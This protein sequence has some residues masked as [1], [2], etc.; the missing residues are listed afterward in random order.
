MRWIQGCGARTSV[1][2]LAA[3]DEGGVDARADQDRIRRLAH[4]H[5]KEADLKEEWGKLKPRDR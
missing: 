2:A 5:M 1:V 3:H 4:K